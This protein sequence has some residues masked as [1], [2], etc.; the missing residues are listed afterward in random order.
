M[1]PLTSSR[2][3]R[4]GALSVVVVGA[5]WLRFSYALYA[6]GHQP[7]MPAPG[8]DPAS[9]YLVQAVLIAPLL[10]AAWL[11]ESLVALAVARAFDDTIDRAALAGGLGLSLAGA[12]GFAFLLPDLVAYR[13]SGFAALAGIVRASGTVTLV[14]LTLTSVIAVR[15]A[16]VSTTARAWAVVVPALLTLGLVVGTLV[17]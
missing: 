3:F 6:D 8:L 14:L 5:V 2:R 4:A 13:V 15:A 16:G 9:H 1:A 12:V 17:R 7:S 10:V 11:L